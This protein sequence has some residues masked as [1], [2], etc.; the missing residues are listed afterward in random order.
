MIKKY[1]KKNLNIDIY[2]NPDEAFVIIQN[3]EYIIKILEKKNQ[4]VEGSVEDKLKT[5]E[6]NRKEYEK[7]FNKLL[8]DKYKIKIEYG[9]CISKF[10]QNKFESDNLKYKI[11]KEIMDEDNIKLFYGEEE[12]YF[13]KILDWIYIKFIN[14]FSKK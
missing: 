6:F 4:N 14:G 11:I 9:F 5:G 12:F 1:F 8:K 3:D 13:D 10:L 7:I 2:K